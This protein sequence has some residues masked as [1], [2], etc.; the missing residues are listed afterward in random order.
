MGYHSASTTLR[1]MEGDHKHA[2]TAHTQKA[3]STAFEDVLYDEMLKP[4]AAARVMSSLD[5]GRI[6]RHPKCQAKHQ[7]RSLGRPPEGQ[8]EHS[9][10][11][12][13][14]EES[15]PHSPP[16]AEVAGQPVWVKCN[17]ANARGEGRQWIQTLGRVTRENFQ[18]RGAKRLV[19]RL[20]Y[21]HA[22]IA[23]DPAMIDTKGIEGDEAYIRKLLKEV[24]EECE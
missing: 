10:Q 15:P 3:C 7:L 20:D 8:H 24:P 19:I 14:E 4:A 6:A 2:G 16:F 9:R 13:E 23:V 21:F 11:V 22:S 5:Q 12:Q 1:N 18:V 17:C